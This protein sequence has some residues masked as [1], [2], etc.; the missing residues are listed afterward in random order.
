MN[1]TITCAEVLKMLEKGQAILVDVMTPEDYACRHIAGA[2]NACVYEMVFLDRIAECVAGKDTPIVL[3]DISGT[4][5]A[6]R[7]AKE[8]LERAGYGSVTI[9]E[10][11]LAAW[12]AAEY[13]LE[14]VTEPVSATAELRDGLYRIDVEKS[15]V[16]W[17]GRNINNRHYGRVPLAGGEVS[18]IGGI[19]AAG[20]FAI[21]MAS[22]ANLDMQ[23]AGWRG[24]LLA[25]LN[26]DDFFDVERYPR[27]TFDMSAAAAI[28]DASPG[29]PNMEIAGTLTVKDSR[30]PLCLQ[31]VVAGQEDGSI[32]AQ[33][34]LDID[35]TR[36]GVD[37]G[38]G[39]LYER[40]GMHL[41][42]DLISIELFIV[43]HPE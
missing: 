39:K 31:A 20:C 19:P 28:A 43:A 13:P 38:S 4:T 15:G 34:Q 32:K 17:I 24:M 42:H 10:G 5:R 26:S 30:R 1:A 29:T 35:R 14:G 21:D 41:V 22:I 11:G 6:A 12:C 9:L 18:I 2:R 25:H 40:L 23:D 36:W 3:C 7:T 8:K 27:A 33:A 16:E 37:Y